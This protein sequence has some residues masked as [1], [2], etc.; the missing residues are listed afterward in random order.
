MTTL[1]GGLKQAASTTVEYGRR[2]VSGFSVL[3]QDLH[4]Q[5]YQLQGQSEI[6][7]SVTSEKAR[8]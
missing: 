2:S 5:N 4:G 8:V 1:Q 7:R 3:A 6:R